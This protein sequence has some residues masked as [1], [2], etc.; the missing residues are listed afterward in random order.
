MA[1]PCLQAT[2]ACAAVVVPLVWAKPQK[3]HHDAAQ[4]RPALGCKGVQ[5]IICAL[6]RISG[7][8]EP[9]RSG[10]YAVAECG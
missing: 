10:G 1:M 7:L 3:R 6:Y 4:T 5:P 8:L 2:V 9:T